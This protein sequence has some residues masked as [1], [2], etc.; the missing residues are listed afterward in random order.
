MRRSG[1]Q[2]N[3][4]GSLRSS[5]NRSGRQ[6][7]LSRKESLRD[8]GRSNDTQSSNLRASLRR[9]DSQSN[10]RGSLRD[11]GRSNDT[12]SSNLRASLRRSDS[13][14]NLRGSLR[15]TL[16]RSGGQRHLSLRGSLQDSMRSSDSEED[17]RSSMRRSGNQINPRGSLRDSQK[18]DNN[19][20]NQRASPRDSNKR[21][22]GQ[23]AFRASLRRSESQ[24]NLR[25]SV[26]VFENI[27][28]KNNTRSASRDSIRSSSSD[29]R[30][31]ARSRLRRSLSQNNLRDSG[32]SS[33]GGSVRNEDL[34]RSIN[35]RGSG[36]RGSR[37]SGKNDLSVSFSEDFDNDVSNQN[38]SGGRNSKLSRSMSALDNWN[39][40]R[41]GDEAN[42]LRKSDGN[43]SD[44]Q[45][46][47]ANGN[48]REIR[49]STM[50]RS[51]PQNYNTIL[52]R[53]VREGSRDNTNTVR[54]STQDSL[55][56]SGIKRISSNNNLR[57]SGGRSRRP[58]LSQSMTSQRSS[59]DSLS[60]FVVKTGNKRPAKRLGGSFT[61]Q[62]DSNNLRSSMRSDRPTTSR[63]IA[64]EERRLSN[65]N[66]P[67][68]S[69]DGLRSSARAN[70]LDRSRIERPDSNSSLRRSSVEQ[71][72]INKLRPSMRDNRTGLSQSL[73]ISD[74]RDVKTR[75][76][77]TRGNGSNDDSNFGKL[78]RL[79]SARREQRRSSGEADKN[80]IKALKRN[81]IL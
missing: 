32:S 37:G 67:Q 73:I 11:S 72:N 77:G 48:V 47:I 6:R 4:R 24:S 80:D 60:G 63:S 50:E 29:G 68:K 51:F 65:S 78:V 45:F 5:L 52:R 1:N 56:C 8:S 7:D 28:K 54:R 40:V 38:Q 34:R 39:A 44:P 21:S 13:Q 20:V 81:L 62:N 55:R 58:S 16:N 18:G 15:S 33:L 70:G 76:S 25:G 46:K 74:A 2:I 42:E 12:Q 19:Q 69:G 31:N 59:D 10:L 43:I 26:R 79:A 57:S 14:S 22:D 35:L 64:N 23:N 71:R 75:R 49:R 3:P 66:G 61:D 30:V 53:S 41:E 27:E 36:K 17:L 9:S